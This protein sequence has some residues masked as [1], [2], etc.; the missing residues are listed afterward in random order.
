MESATDNGSPVSEDKLNNTS[1]EGESA[2]SIV[3]ASS[4]RHRPSDEDSTFDKFISLPRFEIN[5]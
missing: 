3:D 2:E 5:A 1:A 4:E